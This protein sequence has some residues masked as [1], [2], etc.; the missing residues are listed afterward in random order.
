M[1]TSAIRRLIEKL[2]DNEEKVMELYLV[3]GEKFPGH[4]EFWG[5]IAEEEKSHAFLL[6]EL[7]KAADES[8]FDAGAAGIGEEAVDAS[9]VF[10][11]NEIQKAKRGE[12]DGGQAIDLALQIEKSVLESES[13]RMFK[14]GAE[15]VKKLFSRLHE[16]TERHY[17]LMGDM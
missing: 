17:R 4:A 2:A 7:A 13:F 12:T 15:N 8:S 11:E 1:D 5:K 9:I 6:R 10:L 3:F 14:N 16:D